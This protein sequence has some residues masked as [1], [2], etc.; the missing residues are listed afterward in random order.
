MRS[1]ELAGHAVPS[2]ARLHSLSA[3]AEPCER[4]GDEGG[5]GDAGADDCVVTKAGV[6]LLNVDRSLTDDLVEA[7][8]L[9]S[10]MTAA[11]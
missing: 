4:L 2:P 5:S 3:E 7:N 8:G 10:P 9:E 1:R 11:S 6:G